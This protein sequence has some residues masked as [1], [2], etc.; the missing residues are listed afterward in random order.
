MLCAAA[1]LHRARVPAEEELQAVRR[2]TDEHRAQLEREGMRVRALAEA[3]G[4]IKEQRVNEDVIARAAQLRLGE[5]R[6]TRLESIA[7]VF[8]HLSTHVAAFITD[9]QRVSAAVVG[10]TALAGGV[11]GMREATRVV[12]RVID[13]RLSTPALVRETSRFSGLAGIP[14]RLAQALALRTGREGYSLGDVVLQPDLTARL[15]RLSVAIQSTRRNAAPHRNVLFYGP[16]GE[17]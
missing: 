1:C 6:R 2:K 5:E 12:G 16:P 3:E 9:P 10:L 11:Y 7:A 17:S 14:R 8:S 15:A 4:R 13:R